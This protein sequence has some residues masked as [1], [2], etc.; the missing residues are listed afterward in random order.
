MLKWII[1]LLFSLSFGLDAM[2]LHLVLISWLI[3]RLCVDGIM[4]LSSFARKYICIPPDPPPPRIRKSKNWFKILGRRLCVRMKGRS[5]KGAV[6]RA[7]PL[8]LRRHRFFPDKC[9]T[10]F[11]FQRLEQGQELFSMRRL[12]VELVFTFKMFVKMKSSNLLRHRFRYADHLG[13]CA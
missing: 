13:C 1:G 8:R 4:L 2:K 7:F 12:L 3:V 5:Y 11:D 10:L 6:I 9:P